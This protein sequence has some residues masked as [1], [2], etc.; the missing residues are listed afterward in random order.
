MFKKYIFIV[1][2]IASLSNA[3]PTNTE[4]TS[5][6]SQNNPTFLERAQ[7]FYNNNEELFEGKNL[8]I[9]ACITGVIGLVASSI[10]RRISYL[11]CIT[12]ISI[13]SYKFLQSNDELKNYLPS[14]QQ[15]SS[16]VG[17]TA[18][19]LYNKMNQ[20]KDSLQK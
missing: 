17:S 16:Y 18:T 19:N 12:G 15:I 4:T 20:V 5:Q 1:L 2:T 6:S 3:E 11:L 10:T 9:G 14:P 8:A 13:G 7:N